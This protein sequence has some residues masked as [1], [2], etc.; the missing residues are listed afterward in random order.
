MLMS[1]C[2]ASDYYY[3]YYYYYCYSY[4]YYY[5]YS[6]YYRLSNYLPELNMMLLGMLGAIRSIVDTTTNNYM[7]IYIYIYIH[8]HMY[9]HTHTHTHVYTKYNGYQVRVGLSVELSSTLRL[10]LEGNSPCY[11]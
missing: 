5:Y 3:D 7:Y 10:G 11:V 6:Y 4:S 2:A 1:T 8:T 9:I